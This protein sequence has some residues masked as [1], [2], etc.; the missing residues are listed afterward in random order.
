MEELNDNKPYS[1]KEFSQLWGCSPETARQ[2]YNMPNFPSCN[3]G[4]EK[5]ALGSAIRKFFEVPRRR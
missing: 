4:K 5:K 3:Y 2:V 1:I